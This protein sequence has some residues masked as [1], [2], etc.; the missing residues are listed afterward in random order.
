MSRSTRA[1]L[2]WL[3]LL[4]VAAAL[5]LAWWRA[6]VQ[7]CACELCPDGHCEYARRIHVALLAGPGPE[8]AH[9]RD[10]AAF[11]LHAQIPLAALATAVAMLAGPSAPA[12]F[13]LV[14]AAATVL[15]W[16]AL[17]RTL[18]AAG[19]LDAVTRV[20]L[21]LAFWSGAL[22]LRGFARPVSDAVGMACCAWS[23][24]ALVRHVEHPSRGTGLHLL[25]LQFLGHPV[26]RLL[27]ADAGDARACGAYGAIRPLSATWFAERVHYITARRPQRSRR[28]G[29][30]SRASGSCRARVWTRASRRRATSSSPPC[31]IQ[32]LRH[33]ECID[34]AA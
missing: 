16:L 13:A 34:P 28:P 30:P 9:L 3:V 33:F 2:G 10:F 31:F 5:S 11:H 21:A 8:W 24:W 23:L 20:P 25:A 15:A 12:S 22:T 26:A 6:S 7:A 4:L 1:S 14:S 32:A 17:R 27:R 18:T 19:Q 29:R